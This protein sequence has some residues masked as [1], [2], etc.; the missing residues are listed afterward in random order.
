M[1]I[2]AAVHKRSIERLVYQATEAFESRNA[3]LARFAIELEHA[4]DLSESCK[5]PYAERL[6]ALWG[7]TEIINA[8]HEG[9]SVAADEMRD[10][11]SII[12]EI[13]STLTDPANG[14]C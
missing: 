12:R 7:E 8:L 3:S 6:C 13:E 4:V 11:R 14:S 5:S 1:N 9:T 2:E 10:I